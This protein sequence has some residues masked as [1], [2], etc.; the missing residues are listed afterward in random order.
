MLK[1]LLGTIALLFVLVGTAA[2][3]ITPGTLETIFLDQPLP[4]EIPRMDPL[5]GTTAPVV[6]KITVTQIIHDPNDPA[7]IHASGVRKFYGYVVSA[8]VEYVLSGVLGPGDIRMIAPGGD[9]G[10][11]LRVGSTGIVAGRL[12]TSPEGERQLVVLSEN[13]HDRRARTPSP[14]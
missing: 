5:Y 8:R 11:K 1:T 10:D 3:C 4:A 12:E 2:G 6:A 14:K 9:C 7:Q 13:S